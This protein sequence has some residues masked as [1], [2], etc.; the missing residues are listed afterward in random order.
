MK[1]FSFVL[2]I[3][4]STFFIFETCIIKSYLWYDQFLSY[5][6]VPG[7]DFLQQRKDHWNS[8]SFLRTFLELSLTVTLTQLLDS[9]QV[10]AQ[11]VQ[12][13]RSV[14]ANIQSKIYIYISFQKNKCSAHLSSV[15]FHLF[16]LSAKV[17]SNINFSTKKYKLLLLKLSF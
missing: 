5:D 1:T 14:C 8:A 6:T 3:L 16:Y 7:R 13:L 12:N 11:N 4:L 15:F 17:N 9:C 2:I 10:L